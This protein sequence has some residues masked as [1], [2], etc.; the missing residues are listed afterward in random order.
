MT[1]ARSLAWLA[2]VCLCLSG[3]AL[4]A[5]PAA[6][7]DG[8]YVVDGP[9]IFPMSALA[10][11]AITLDHGR[12]SIASGC[13]PVPATIQRAADGTWS[14]SAYWRRCEHAW[15]VRLKAQISSDCREMS[16]A[17]ASRRPRAVR[18]FTARRCE[19]PAG[20]PALCTSNAECPAASY[21]A[22]APGDC[23]GEGKCAVRPQACPDVWLPVC[24]C[25]RRT[26]GNMCEAAAAGVNVA[27]PGEC[28]PQRCDAANPCPAGQF[29][30]LPPGVCASGL[31]AG[32]CVEIPDLCQNDICGNCE[33]PPC[34]LCPNIYQPVCG[35]DGVTYATDCER[36]KA[37]VSKSHD[38]ECACPQ[39]LCAPGTE[40]V[41]R[42]GDGCA[43]SCLAPCRDVCDCKVNP[44]IRLNND[45]PLLCVTCGDHWTCQNG[46]CVEECG[47]TPPD[48]CQICGG[49]AG[50]PCK[51]GEVCDLPPGQCSS[52]DLF[53]RCV[54]QPE[55]CITLYDPV[56]GCDGVTYGNDCERLRVG[57][58]KDHDGICAR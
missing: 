53:G 42:D 19:D 4:A 54:L 51:P 16:G 36:R 17:V 14:V 30:E 2:C 57:A 52:A 18:R 23:A 33:A 3:Q 31:D 1:C 50:F 15:R 5:H 45:C 48:E 12:V 20:C 13:D 22:K 8:T 25:D 21:C 46:H 27:H 37:A 47:P 32:V 41:D 56:C 34:P 35:C 49:I 26:Y 58:Q 38:G 40:P 7:P 39:I 9:P 44:N 10:R 11:D 6:C 43:E 24:G 28:E 29:C 55:A